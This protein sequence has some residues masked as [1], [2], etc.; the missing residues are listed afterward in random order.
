MKAKEVAK[1]LMMELQWGTGFYIFSIAGIYLA[2]KWGR[3][4]LFTRRATVTG[5]IFYILITLILVIL[6]AV[7]KAGREN[8][9]ARSVFSSLLFWS[10]MCLPGSTLAFV[11]SVLC[12][13]LAGAIVGVKLPVLGLVNWIGAWLIALVLG[14]LKVILTIGTLPSCPKVPSDGG[15]SYTTQG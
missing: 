11:L 13:Y 1:W 15:G 9:P 10:G 3:S 6:A 14:L 7:W 4:P 12:F 8:K 5:F 2:T